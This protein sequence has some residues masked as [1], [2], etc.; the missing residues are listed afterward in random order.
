MALNFE[1]IKRDF[2]KHKAKSAVLGVLALTMVGL[3][4]KAAV[5]MRPRSAAAESPTVATDAGA[6]AADGGSDTPVDAEER[7]R[8]SRELW[9][10]LRET[11]GGLGAEN[12]F[13]FDPTYFP[14]D[15]NQ[16]L[17]VEP[18]HVDTVDH[19][20]IPVAPNNEELERA[21]RVSSIREQARQLI[22]H[23]TV[24]GNGASQSI[25]V[26]NERIL[27]VGDRIS[28]FEILSIRAREVEFKKD[29]ITL[30][31]KMADDSSAQ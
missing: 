14:M 23:S 13:T 6:A 18:Q 26:V 28:G 8:Q 20:G 29:G 7:I 9:K 27:K 16:P 25:A 30:A 19:T 12:A 2:T 10:V 3:F 15:P 1:Q 24:V 31:V 21:A 17:H 5:E 4:L 22:V 11:H